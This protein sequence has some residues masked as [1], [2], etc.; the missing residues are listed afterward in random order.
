MKISITTPSKTLVE[1]DC[2]FVLV[3]G[4]TGEFA[5]LENHIPIIA[6]VFEGFIKFR[7]QDNETF[8]AISGGIVDQKNNVITVIAQ[9]AV[10]A[11]S[12]EEAVVELERLN[13][14][15]LATNRRM[16]KEFAFSETE[17]KRSIQASKSGEF[18]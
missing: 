15:L 2:D 3:H 14:E 4:P 5:M 10:I 1:Q 6:T 7:H 13:E 18:V 12:Q 11:N 9:A 16:E 17:L 8:V